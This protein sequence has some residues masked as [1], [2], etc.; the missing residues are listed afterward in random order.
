MH[1]NTVSIGIWDEE[2]VG[3]HEREVLLKGIQERFPGRDDTLS[4]I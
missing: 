4:K 2:E 3:V 1:S